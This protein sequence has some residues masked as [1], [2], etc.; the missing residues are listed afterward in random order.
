MFMPLETLFRRIV[1]EGDLTV[2]GADGRACKFGNGTGQAVVVR[3]MDRASERRIAFDPELAAGEAYMQDR[4][5]FERGSFYDL[6]ALVLENLRAAPFPGMA[7]NSNRWRTMLRPLA[8][9]NPVDRSRRNVTHHYDIDPRIY[10][11]FLD[12]DRQYSCAYFDGARTLEQAQANKKRHIAAKLAIGPRNRV[13]D[14][15]SGWGGLALYL[16]R[17]ADCHVTGVTLS[18]E[19]WTLACRRAAEAGL[20]HA[21]DFRL[22]DYRCIDETFDRIVSVG[23][24][25]HVGLPHYATYF[26]RVAD[27]LADD[28]VALIHTIGRSGPPCPTNP[29]IAKYI[30]PGGALPS[31][32]EILE[33]VENAGLIVADVE[34][35]RLHYA[36]TLR[37]W[38]ERFLA[39]RA[40]AVA[41][42][43]ET[44]TRMWEV[45]LA[46]SEAGFRFQDLV[47]FQIQLTKRVDALPLT[48]DYIRAGET[49]LAAREADA[50]AGEPALAAPG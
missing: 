1:R 38:R 22:V 21:V 28:G 29:F 6:A 17:T 32:S 31:L 14:I 13:L 34:V 39:R 3:I 4:L 44:F 25:E 15:G 49:M 43:G 48:R 23:M 5:R 20:T 12:E 47:V 50:D 11:L 41:I 2:I 37:L 10:D 45:Y 30:F 7:R 19:Q 40:E 46:G 42:A 33:A 26:Q 18:R 24:F 16:A 27:L 9:Y 36:E 8:Q 35:L